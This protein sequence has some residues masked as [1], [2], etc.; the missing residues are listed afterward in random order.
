MTVSIRIVTYGQNHFDG[1]QGGLDGIE[2]LASI[3]KFDE[4]WEA[5][6]RAKYPDASIEFESHPRV[7]GI[8]SI[9]VDTEEDGLIDPFEADHIKSHISDLAQALFVD[10]DWLVYK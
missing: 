8:D 5:A 1:W 2:T 6:I 9:E 7:A 4:M 10:Y 3:K